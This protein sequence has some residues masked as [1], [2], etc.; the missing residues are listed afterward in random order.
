MLMASLAHQDWTLWPLPSN[1]TVGFTGQLSCCI[2]LMHAAGSEDE[3]SLHGV[4][5]RH[6]TLHLDVLLLVRWCG[7]REI[8]ALLKN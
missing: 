2:R 4:G 3:E 5:G 8:R 1:W 6:A 7:R